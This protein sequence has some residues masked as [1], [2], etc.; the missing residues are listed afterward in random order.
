VI[1]T[2]RVTVRD[3]A[4]AA[5]L[6]LIPVTFLEVSLGVL[7]RDLTDGRVGVMSVL[8]GRDGLLLVARVVLAV[9]LGLWAA[10][11]VRQTIAAGKIAGTDGSG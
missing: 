5:L 4:A 9:V 11:I 6:G 3:N 8:F 10:R 2:T 7:G 1:A